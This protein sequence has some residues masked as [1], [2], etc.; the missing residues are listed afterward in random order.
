M[1]QLI[2]ILFIVVSKPII[3]NNNASLSSNVN[4][5]LIFS[6]ASNYITLLQHTINE[7][8][9][10]YSGKLQ[11]HFYDPLV[12]EHIYDL[13]DPKF[14]NLKMDQV[15]S[16]F[17]YA[18]NANNI[19]KI[20]IDFE[21]IKIYDCTYYNPKT[22]TNYSYVKVTKDFYYKNSSRK[23]S[24]NHLLEININNPSSYKITNVY[25]LND[26][27]EDLYVN[28]CLKINTNAAQLKKLAIR[29]DKLYKE[30]V[31]LY[32]QKEYL[33]ALQLI[34]DIL[35][36][37]NQYT[38][39]IDGKQAILDLVD[40]SYLEEKTQA[41]LAKDDF[42]SASKIVAISKK[43]SIGSISEINKLESLIFKAKEKKKQEIEFK[44]AENYFN[45][46]MY[47]NALKIYTS[48]EI[49]GFQNTLLAARIYTCKEADPNLIKKRITSAYN[50]AVSSDQ[51]YK[52]TF[53]TYYKYENSGYLKGSNYRFMCLMMIGKGNK[54]LL[55]KMNISKNQAKNMAINYF[56]KAKK[57][58]MDMR[59][60]EFIVFTKN[61]N[62][63]RKK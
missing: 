52:N 25:E 10:S 7:K 45:L 50:N 40:Y 4:E 21:S 2:L 34:E 62:K 3:A 30:V 18:K 29:N 47:A 27:N 11:E 56:F 44:E 53:K 12:S 54:S 49:K 55:R 57:Y 24:V 42:I 16:Y 31:A 37:N 39:A 28:K 8:N 9:E 38:Q 63:Q 59:D 33:E 35:N 60:I 17:S 5:N 23:S 41:V 13:N 15:W 1:K 6:L 61:F 43:N 14:S 26:T 46:E 22:S 48:L 32:A 20:D 51:H 19:E 36:V 58:G